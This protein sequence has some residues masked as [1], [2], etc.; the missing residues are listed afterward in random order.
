MKCK[1][2][3]V[4]LFVL[5]SF[6]VL[7]AA[8]SVAVKLYNA[9]DGVYIN[10]GE[11]ISILNAP[12]GDTI[13][14]QLQVFVENDVILGGMSLGFVWLSPDGANIRWLAQVD[15]W[16]K[17]GQN[18]GFAAVTVPAASRF[19][20]APS[21]G[22]FDLTGL[23]VTEQDVDGTVPDS[24]LLGGVALTKGVPVG[25]LEHFFSF[26]FALTDIADG[27]VKQFVIDSS[28]VGPV[29]DFVLID[30]F[31]GALETTFGGGFTLTATQVPVDVDSDNP[32]VP[33]TFSLSQN[34]PNPFNPRTVIKYSVAR[35]SEVNIS[36]FNILGQKVTTLVDGEVEA[37]PN[38]AI[39]DGY[40]GSGNQVASGIYFYKMTTTDFVETRKMVLMR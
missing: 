30:A 29:G 35:K 7:Q 9:T 11:N 22:S 21:T 1:L 15:G 5:L 14:Y 24:A 19:D 4:S 37:G 23:L 40:D 13:E 6:G 25:A 34:Y 12:A 32:T 20:P 27:E 31:G 16:G 17:D 3:M 26:H 39:W 10:D 2:L 36:V 38:Q 28:K 8:D 18:T 33:A